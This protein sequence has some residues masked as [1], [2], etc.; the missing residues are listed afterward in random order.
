M[1][2]QNCLATV[3]P[4]FDGGS[5]ERNVGRPGKN[6][7]A[8]MKMRTQMPGVRRGMIAAVLLVLGSLLVQ[9]GSAQ[10]SGYQQTNLV[11]DGTV[12]A[13]TTDPALINPWGIAIGQQTPFWVN[14][15]GSG[16]SAV[17]DASG[18]KQFVVGLPPKAGGTSPSR[19]T[20]IVF[21]TPGTGFSLPGSSSATFIFVTLDGTVAGWNANTPNA[22][23]A[24]DN[25]ASGAVYTGAALLTAQ[26][27]NLLLAANF[28]KGKIDVLDSQFAPATLSGGF[29]DP[30]LP[31][32]FSPYGIHNIGGNIY[33]AYAQQPASGG[34][35]VTG[36]GL[37]YVN[38]FDPNGNLINRVA[39]GGTLN[40]PWGVVQ[41]P[42]SF[43]PFGGDLLVG[44]FGD[45]TVNAFDPTS[46][47]FKG[48]L[49]NASGNVIANSGLWDLVFGVQGTGDVNTLYFSAG[50]NGEKGGVFGAL[51]VAQ[52]TPGQGD[53]GLALSAPSLT[54]AAGQSGTL[55]LNLSSM[56]SFTGV[57]DFA[58]SGLPAGSSCTFSPT[59]VNLNGAAASTIVTIATAGRGSGPGQNPYVAKL[60]TVGL[61]I[62]AAAFLPLG[63]AAFLF[64]RKRFI[65]GLPVLL[66]AG[67]LSGTLFAL[68]GCGSKAS[69]AT[70]PNPTP[71]NFNVTITG[72]SGALSHAAMVSLTVN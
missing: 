39:S 37:G 5:V 70:S 28:S 19:P 65:K 10:T 21:N 6:A 48:Q 22:I 40:A 45:G 50:L 41:A 35:P 33:V 54:V 27:G 72:T 12:S 68:S 47:T 17:Y 2:T 20:G 31:A 15:A 55:T 11:S 4:E 53:F 56:Q 29:T 52:P 46:F 43:G 13:T 60:S 42:A 64:R 71:A 44:N 18:T 16:A 32:G 30:N 36:A 59:S 57:V 67:L 58:C 8:G 7:A 14:E 3:T 23:T 9:P 1:K 63:L 34:P 26:S 69:M 51:S 66:A 61:P 49:Q 24:V 38:A 62:S 25:S